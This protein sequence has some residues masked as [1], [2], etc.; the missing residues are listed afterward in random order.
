[1]NIYKVHFENRFIIISPE[2]DRLQ[3][4]GLFHKFYD[5]KE[6]YK[7]ISTFQSDK[8][9]QSINIYGPDIKFI[10]KIFRIYFTEV[11]AAGG[12]VRHS[13]GKYLF[14]EKNGKWD[15]PKGHLER[16]EDPDVCALREVH[17]ECGISNHKIIKSLQPSYHTYMWEGISYLKKTNWF[18]MSY[19][20]EIIFDPQTEEGITRVLW[21]WPDEISKIKNTAWLSLADLINTSILRG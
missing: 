11:E 8:E 1:M 6:L 21:L 16:G 20:D 4:Y 13:S 14:I 5:T 12:L 3:K 19:N 15:L 17:E 9:I 10:W 18:L 2:P 7:L